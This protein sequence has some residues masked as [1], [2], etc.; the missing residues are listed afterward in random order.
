MCVWEN[1]LRQAFHEAV[2]RGYSFTVLDIRNRVRSLL[3]TTTYQSI[4]V[5]VDY[6]SV[7]RELLLLLERD[8]PAGWALTTIPIVDE[9]GTP[10]N[11]WQ[12]TP[13]GLLLSVEQ[14]N[15]ALKPP[16]P[17]P[18]ASILQRILAWGFRR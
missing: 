13:I 12:V 2:I 10:H 4:D 7:Q 18:R 15:R 14:M 5:D 8:R 17:E 11:V 3:R 9:N 16:V 1:Q 6:A